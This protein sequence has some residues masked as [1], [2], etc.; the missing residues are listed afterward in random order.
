MINGTR[1]TLLASLLMLSASL[2][3]GAAHAETVTLIDGTRMQAEVVHA[4]KGEFTLKT[5]EGEIT[6]EKGRIKSIVFEAP[7][8]RAIYSTP[9]KT[10]EAWRTATLGADEKG[11]TEAYA[12]IYQGTVSKQMEDMDFKS[13]SSL[14]A[15]VGKTKF[16]VKDRKIEKDKATLTVE[17]EKDWETRSGEIRFVLENG[18]WKMTP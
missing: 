12:L 8:A 18:E 5:A 4:Y 17:Q 2:L 9:E 14:V 1:T 16:T 6:V 13:R 15:D 11:M 10:L 3:G 7:V